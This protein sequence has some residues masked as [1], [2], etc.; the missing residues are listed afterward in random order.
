MTESPLGSVL[1]ALDAYADSDD[2][3][4]PGPER[5]LE[6]VSREIAKIHG[7]MSPAGRR[8]RGAC[9]ATLRAVQAALGVAPWGVGEQTA[10]DAAV[11]AAIRTVVG[12]LPWGGPPDVR[13]FFA[14]T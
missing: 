2:D 3:E 10:E 9:Y 11:S 1:D 14:V 5:L 12:D 4:L 6:E 13:E 8:V 7:D